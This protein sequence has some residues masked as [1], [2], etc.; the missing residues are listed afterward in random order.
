MKWLHT[1]S[2][3]FPVEG[4]RADPIASFDAYY[5]YGLGLIR[6]IIDG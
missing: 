1:N 6:G 3:P 4:F 2:N 5:G